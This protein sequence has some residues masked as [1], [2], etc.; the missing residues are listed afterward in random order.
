MPQVKLANAEVRQLPWQVYLVRE[1][2]EMLAR[3]VL[4]NCLAWQEAWCPFWWMVADLWMVVE[5]WNVPVKR[6]AV[7]ALTPV[8]ER[9]VPELHWWLMV[10]WA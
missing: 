1:A 6:L 2:S 9:T 7:V 8:E 3:S 10:N 4:V 5:R